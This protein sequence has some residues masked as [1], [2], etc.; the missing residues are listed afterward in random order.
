MK[1]TRSSCRAGLAY[2]SQ[3][4]HPSPALA[5]RGSRCW[6]LESR[7]RRG[8]PTSCY[9]RPACAAQDRGDSARHNPWCSTAGHTISPRRGFH[10]LS[11]GW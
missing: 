7:A 2:R 3:S 11:E 10:D 6:D 1:N 9:G 4:R 8:D 5:K